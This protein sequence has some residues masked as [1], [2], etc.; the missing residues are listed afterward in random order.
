M[1][2]AELETTLNWMVYKTKENFPFLC[3]LFL[4]LWGTYF[5]NRLLGGALFYLG[6]VPR[7]WYGIQ[8]I[9]FSPFLHG[10]FNHLFFNTI[11]LLILSNFILMTGLD[12]F[13]IVSVLI[14]LL[15]G[16][17]I[18]LFGRRGLH[19]GASSV[20]TGYWSF[21]IMNMFYQPSLM[22]WILGGLSVYYFA[23]IFL[24][25]FPSEEDVAWEGHLFGLLAGICT[26][27]LL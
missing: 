27:Y 24:G 9:L 21:L 11:P 2:F 14:I 1:N 4:I 13:L 25:I 7:R 6:L 8:G 23:G 22:T 10:N 19:I 17:L 15:S 12:Y 20:I 3:L 26:S 16:I 5:L 18:W